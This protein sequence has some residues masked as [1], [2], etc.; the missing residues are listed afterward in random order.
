[1]IANPLNVASNLVTD[2]D[3]PPRYDNSSKSIIPPAVK[4]ID[5]AI[6]G[7]DTDLTT[8][9]NKNWVDN[10]SYKI[11]RIEIADAGSGYTQ[12]PV[13]KFVGQDLS[14][15][16]TGTGATALAKLGQGG[17]IASVE[18]TTQGTGYLKSQ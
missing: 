16:E 7:T 8:Y 1:M 14:T 15:S 9:P 5:N 13:L 6:V 11:K 18:I 17:K 3:L 4:V 10:L 2:F 12:P